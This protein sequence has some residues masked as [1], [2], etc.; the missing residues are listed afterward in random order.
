MTIDALQAAQAYASI[1][2]AASPGSTS[3]ATGVGRGV[4]GA[5]GAGASQANFAE[6]VTHAFDDAVSTIRAGEQAGLDVAAGEAD[7]VDV[8]TAVSA[9]EISLEAAIAVRN[10]M[11]EAY[12]EIMR[13]PI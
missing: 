12:Q 6:L 13:M 8:A 2:Q 1:A 10:R 11:I 4:G 9:A 3:S 5:A 7:V